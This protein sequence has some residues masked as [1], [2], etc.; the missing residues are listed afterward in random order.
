MLD[1]WGM[2]RWFFLEN[3]VM[4]LEKDML[5]LIM[6][7]GFLFFLFLNLFEKFSFSFDVYFVVENRKEKLFLLIFIELFI[8]V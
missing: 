6:Y 1:S 2:C 7:I 5:L 4:F 8:I 3:L